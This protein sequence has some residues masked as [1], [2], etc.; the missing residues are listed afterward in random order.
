MVLESIMDPFKAEKKPWEM[1]FVGFIYSSIAVFLSLWIFKQHS[2]LIMVFLTVMACIPLIYNTMKVEEKRD[3]LEERESTILKEHARALSF[4]VFLFL[5][6]TI[7]LSIW[8][9]VL[10]SNITQNLFNVQTR[11]IAE[12]NSQITGGAVAHL[13]LFVKV[14]FN[15]IK[16]MIFCLLFSFIY[17]VGAIFILTWNAS[18]IAAAIGNFIRSNMSTISSYFA[19]APL[20]LL[21]YLIHGIPEILGYFTAGLAGGFI[22]IAVIR[23]DFGTQKFEH[24]IL[25]STDLMILSI[26]II[27]VAAA[28]EVWVTPLLF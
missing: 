18:V 9:I 4:L 25:D 15:N 10:P 24:I 13:N 6:I 3:L 27:F 17:G 23:H 16:V 14:F 28:I 22:S 1:F 8:Y 2:S 26:A 12:I 21:R 11:T 5:G 19:I 20:G 7:S